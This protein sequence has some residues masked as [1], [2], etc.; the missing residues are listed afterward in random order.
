MVSSLAD[1]PGTFFA[2]FRFESHA[3]ATATE[4]RQ[5]GMVAATLNDSEQL[6]ITSAYFKFDADITGAAGNSTTV[7]TAVGEDTLQEVAFVL[8]TN[9]TAGVAAGA[10][11]SAVAVWN[12]PLTI[13]FT[14]VGTGLLIP[15]GVLTIAYQYV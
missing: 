10:I 15:G 9:A 1:I 12:E 4:T 6:K 3:A 11:S 2:T 14:K 13:T 8:N 7:T 5:Y